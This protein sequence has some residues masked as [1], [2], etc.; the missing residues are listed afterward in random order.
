MPSSREYLLKFQMFVSD[1]IQTGITVLRVMLYSKRISRF[2]TGTGECYIL[3]NGPS[4]NRSL[5]ELGATMESKEILCAN[6]F[7][8]SPMF[9]KL[10][11]AY[12]FLIAPE[13][14]HPEVEE[15]FREKSR[16]LFDTL[17]KKTGWPLQMFIP[18]EARKHTGWQEHIRQNSNISVQYINVTPVEGLKW[19]RFWMYDMRRGMP[20]PHN[21]LIPTLLTAIQIGFRKI[22]LFGADHS[23]LSEISV[24]EQNEVLVNQKHFYDEA[25]AKPRPMNYKGRRNRKLHEVLTKFVLAF[26]GYHE[27]SEYAEKRGVTIINATPGSFIDAFKR[28][29]NQ[30]Y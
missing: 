4:L 11:P 30:K 7:P 6:Y 29:T 8:T 15:R 3:M 28:E 1:I 9:E 25:V 20:R 27:L 2:P 24:N 26:K 18:V 5:E 16:E 10:Q 12:Y 17:G 22:H 23:W 21:V 13:L 14:W 19:F